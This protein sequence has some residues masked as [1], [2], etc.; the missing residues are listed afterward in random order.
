MEQQ[1]QQTLPKSYMSDAE[2]EELKKQGASQD[3]FYL[4][5]CGAAQDA[6]DLD[7]AWAWIAR[8]ELPAYSL[9]FLKKVNGAE[10]IRELNFNTTEAD[11]VYGKGWLDR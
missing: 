9:S 1:Q 11:R 2:R 5:E 4:V 7:A 10:F 6:G 8:C 3:L